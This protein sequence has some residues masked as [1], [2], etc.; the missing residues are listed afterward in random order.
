[1]E[2]EYHKMKAQLAV[3]RDVAETYAHCNID[4]IIMQLEEQIKH[5]ESKNK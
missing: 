3:L 1:M 2:Y 4:N 5:I